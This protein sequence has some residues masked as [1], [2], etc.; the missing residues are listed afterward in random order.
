MTG[1]DL[2]NML[3]DVE[4]LDAECVIF[5]DEDQ[6]DMITEVE[7]EVQENA[8]EDEDEDF[9]LKT[10]TILIIPTKYGEW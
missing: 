3:M 7:V 1:R 6:N 4:D 8:Y 5:S 2:M 10:G 9:V